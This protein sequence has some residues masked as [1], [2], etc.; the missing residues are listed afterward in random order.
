M[1]TILS[2]VNSLAASRQ[3]GVTKIDLNRTITR[4]VGS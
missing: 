3:L 2:N 1:V 4:Q